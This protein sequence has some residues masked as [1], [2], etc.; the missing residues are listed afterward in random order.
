MRVAA[1]AVAVFSAVLAAGAAAQDGAASDRA[2]LEALYDATGGAGW[3]DGTSWK[4]AAPLG[5]WHG[6][7]TD[8]AGRVTG[9]DLA[10]NG[11]IGS[12]PPVLGSLARLR[13]LDLGGNDLTGPIPAALGNLA[14][15]GSLSLGRNAL[16]GRIP[17]Q[18]GNLVQLRRLDLSW[19][20]LAG[21]IPGALGSLANLESLD[22]RWNALTGPVPAWLGNL[23]RLRFLIIDVNALAG[24]IPAELANLADLEELDLSS[25]PL[26]GTLPRGLA[27]L[28]RLARLDIIVTAACAPGD[29]AFQEWLAAID[30]S[31]D[32]CNRSPE[33][34][35]AIPAQALT[36][37][38]PALGV[39]VEAHFSDP[40]EDPLTYSAVSSHSGAVGVLVSD[41]TVWLAP[42]AVGTATVTVTA[43]APDGL[44]ADQTLVV[45][46]DASAGPRDDREVLEAFYDATGGE[47]WTDGTGWKSSAP[48]NQWH[49]VT[50]GAAG[51]VTRLDLADNGLTGSIPPVLGRLASLEWLD[52]RENG[53]A[54]RIPGALGSLENLERLE[55]RD[56]ALTGPIPGELE[57]LAS[58][59]WLFLR[60][61]ALTG[62]IP[63][64]LGN[65]TRLQVLDFGWNDLTGPIP[66]ELGRL[67]R[68]QLLGL[69]DNALTGAVPDELGRLSKLEGL[70][71]AYNWGLSGPLPPDLRLPSLEVL[72]LLVTGTCAPAVWE[73]RLGEITFTGR[74]CESETD[75]TIDVAVVYTRGAREAA[76]GAAA[77]EAE[78][79][80]LIAETNQ[81]YAA[82][83]VR[84]RVALVERSE[85]S[86]A[87][88]GDGR[89][90]I[91]RLADP[92]DDHLDEVH[93]LRDRVGA[94]LVHVIVAEAADI[95]GIALRPGAFSLTP[96][97]CGS[98]SFAHELGHN[99]G[100][101][102]DRYQVHHR[103]GGV[104]AHPAYGYV[105][106]RG[107]TAGAKRSTRWLTIPTATP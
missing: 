39:S 5:E 30:F 31:G 100:L 24:P 66:G 59:D 11:L 106:Q 73:D 107:V 34:V 4:T 52:L 38:G 63:P 101:E 88:T 93:D 105:N 50:T 25:N 68:L 26:T 42:G 80:L 71:L 9:L 65:L 82:S 64:W 32:T 98:R 75:P 99:M 19:N 44:S 1:L 92:S 17:A 86:Y 55:L 49:G 69:F 14:N 41:D 78:I 20:D 56:N 62:P 35:D 28:S 27:R 95:C 36:E 43:R 67:V 58:L 77:I 16:T 46:V 102:H 81:T 3:T 13:W 96:H 51:R 53:L 23:S 45:T 60:S 83:G 97:G 10:Y 33:P 85:V 22:L 90:D 91:L 104:S 29:A 2:A 8:V 70:D 57:G 21:P 84:H 18:L 6:V 103:E 61:N 37:A 47:D 15:L 74:R 87:G 12:L 76:G 72:D 54:G 7:T 79:D 40:D 89:V 94:D 48:L